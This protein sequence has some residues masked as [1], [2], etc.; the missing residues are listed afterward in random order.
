MQSLSYTMDLFPVLVCLT[1]LV[2]VVLWTVIANFK[3]TNW[4]WVFLLVPLT[5]GSAVTIYQT[6]SNLLGYA[7]WLQIPE[8]SLYQWHAESLDESHIIVVVYPPT[9]LRTRKFAIPNTEQNRESMNQ[10]KEK[11]ERG[12]P[13]QIRQSEENSNNGE[14]RGGEYETYDFNLTDGENLKQQQREQEQRT[15]NAPAPPTIPN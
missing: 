10:A 13:Q 8:D 6:V 14:T 5:L 3:S 15:I 1:F 11:S 9:E 12:N 7:V 2:I 4:L